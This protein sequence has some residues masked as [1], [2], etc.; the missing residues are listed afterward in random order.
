MLD[1]YQKAYAIANVHASLLTLIQLLCGY[2]P[3]SIQ[4]PSQ[5]SLLT[6]NL[7]A[8]RRTPGLAHLMETQEHPSRYL[9]KCEH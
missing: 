4:M 5:T 1:G 7:L 9:Q 2:R 8:R 3:H 6:Q